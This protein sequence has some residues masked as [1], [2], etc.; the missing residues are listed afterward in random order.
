MAD[1]KLK[2]VKIKLLAALRLEL[3]DPKTNKP[4]TQVEIVTK[5]SVVTVSNVEATYQCEMNKA[6]LVDKDVQEVRVDTSAKVKKE[7]K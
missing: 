7:P 6:E 4:S 5:G 2:P 3:W 1:N